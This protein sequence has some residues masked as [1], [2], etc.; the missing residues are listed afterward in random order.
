MTKNKLNE[1]NVGKHI[2][3][4]FNIYENMEPVAADC[5]KLDGNQVQY[6]I[7]FADGSVSDWLVTFDTNNSDSIIDAE[8]FNEVI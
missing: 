4:Y 1:G 2:V 6:R 5:I 3:L 7:E 8:M